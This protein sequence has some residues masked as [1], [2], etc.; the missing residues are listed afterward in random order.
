M[1]EESKIAHQIAET[2]A[3]RP[4][5]APYAYDMYDSEGDLRRWPNLAP[6]LQDCN[7][8]V[9]AAHFMAD[10][11][12][13]RYRARHRWV[14]LITAICGMLAVLFAVMQ[15]SPLVTLHIFWAKQAEIVAAVVA[16]VAVIFGLLAA[17][18]R[19]WLLERDRAER[20]RLLKFRFLISPKLW[21]GTTCKERQDWL[22]KQIKS[23]EAWDKNALRRWAE[24]EVDDSETASTGVPAD[25]DGAVLTDLIDYY[26]EKRLNYQQEYF[27]GQ[28]K[29]R[30]FLDRF[31]R[32][33]PFLFFFLSILAALGHYIYDLEVGRLSELSLHIA[34]G[35]AESGAGP[36]GD[37]SSQPEHETT[38]LVL[39]IA[40][41]CFPV[42]GAAVRTLRTA[43]EFGRNALRFQATSNELKRLRYH[44]RKKQ[45][46]QAR[47]QVLY[48][49]E[50]VLEAERREWLRLMMEAEWFG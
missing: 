10:S 7:D 39:L 19:H 14:V 3:R 5:E 4:P 25:V 44:L 13:T 27:D 16:V 45:D 37:H 49:V 42:I 30:H 43:H 48:R 20:Y 15:L 34:E 35:E 29:H 8:T 47:L 11:A 26:Q 17:F 32:I 18:S 24:S 41:A 36:L 50:K 28:A 40:A 38:G 23:F 31:T 9:A 22:H 12:A 33:A 6:I 1:S 2:W 46:A 21:S